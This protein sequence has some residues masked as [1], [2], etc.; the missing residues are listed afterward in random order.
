MGI[1]DRDMRL[2]RDAMWA[3]VNEQGWHGADIT[4]ARRL[5]A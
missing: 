5:T 4:P 3:V 2:V 1:P